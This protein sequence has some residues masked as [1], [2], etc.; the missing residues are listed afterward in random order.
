MRRSAPIIFFGL[1]AANVH[2]IVRRPSN[3]VRH[4]HCAII[5]H[6]C[7]EISSLKDARQQTNNKLIQSQ[8]LPQTYL[9][10]T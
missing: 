10:S 5:G 4:N 7:A 2:L 8:K 6:S 3:N 1:L 9:R